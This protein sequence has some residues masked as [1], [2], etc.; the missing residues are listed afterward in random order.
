MT[1][2][3]RAAL[4]A[5]LL[6]SMAVPAA[7]QITGRPFEVSVGA[8]MMPLMA[9]NLA[10]WHARRME[11]VLVGESGAPD[12][13]ALQLTVA[14]R[15]LPWSVV[16]P[17]FALRASAGKPVVPVVDVVP[18]VASLPWLRAMTMKDGRATAYVCQ[19]FVCQSP[20]TDPEQ[21]RA[22]LE[23]AMAPRRIMEAGSSD[24]ASWRD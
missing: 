2:S 16:V 17:A 10:L 15:Y 21:L 9:A 5:A 14:A 12:L 8:G 23:D 19:D 6:V 11:I 18:V 4:A 7:G 24:P 3:K 1:W 13:T 22:Q 20:T